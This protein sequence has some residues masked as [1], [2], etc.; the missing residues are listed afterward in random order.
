MTLQ[1]GKDGRG[2]SFILAQRENINDVEFV[3]Q[4]LDVLA[5][6]HKIN[7][8]RVFATGISNG[9]AMSHRIAAEASDVIAGQ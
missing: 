2:K 9:A 1:K 6:E 5:E 3:R 4:L 7:R 8:G